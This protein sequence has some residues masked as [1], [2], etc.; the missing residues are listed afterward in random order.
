MIQE[1]A[2]D[3]PKEREADEWMICFKL[4]LSV[5]VFVSES[6]MREEMPDN[7]SSTDLFIQIKKAS[8][9]H[10]PCNIKHTTDEPDK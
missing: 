9:E 2:F 1:D 10:L 6:T 4:S 3:A 7:L 8:D 5:S